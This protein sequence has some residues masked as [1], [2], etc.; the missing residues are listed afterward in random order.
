MVK[1][2]FLL[3]YRNLKR[4]KSSF[5]INLIGLSVGLACALSI[6]LWVNS[7]M[8]V[9]KFFKKD[10]QLFQVMEHQKHTG[11]IRVTDSTPGLLSKALAEEMP[12]VEYATTATPT[13]WFG[14]ITLSVGDKNI[15]ANGKYAGKDFFKIFSYHLIQGNKNQLLSD[16]KSIVISK[17]LALKLFD[18]TQDIVGKTIEWQHSIQYRV[19]GIFEVPA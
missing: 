18:S 13:Y 12:E 6:F 3:I 17:K 16:T 8:H 9:D 5:F 2:T 14:G 7:E 10:S 19:S 1:H 11:S 4:F 15:E